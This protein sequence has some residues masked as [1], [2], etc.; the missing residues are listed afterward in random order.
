MKKVALFFL[1]TAGLLSA[2]V[3]LSAGMGISFI[4][5]SSLTDYIN[6]AFADSDNKMADFT[7]A[8]EFSGEAD[9]DVAPRYQIGF[10]YA[11]QIYSFNV[12]SGKAGLYDFSYV[13]HRPSILGYYIWEGKG[14]KLKLGAGFGLRYIAAEEQVRTYPNPVEY[15]AM[16]FGIIGRG[17]AHTALDENVFAFLEASLN[18]DFPGELSDN[19]DNKII[20]TSLDENVNM[21][22]VSTTIK[23][24]ISYH[25]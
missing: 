2:Q 7:S 24:G 18:A 23:V 25:F 13:A 12:T 17:Q 10:E 14:Y 8:V 9:F 1:L 20:N 22:S 21:N 16:G 19:D 11:T 4:N 3:D 15:S 5:T 6:Y